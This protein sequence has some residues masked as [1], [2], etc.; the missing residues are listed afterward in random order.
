MTNISVYVP[1]R[2]TEDNRFEKE[3]SLRDRT[4]TPICHCI[5]NS[6]TSIDS[7]RIGKRR[8]VSEVTSG[9]KYVVREESDSLIE[10]D[11]PTA[12][13][14]YEYR[15]VKIT[16]RANRTN[17]LHLTYYQLI[18]S[19]IRTRFRIRAWRFRLNA[20]GMS[21]RGM[22]GSPTPERTRIVYTHHIYSF[23][24]Y[25]FNAGEKN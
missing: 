15:Y 24:G 12:W 25:C 6:F 17:P 19:L 2:W 18:C 7:R 10:Y 11:I 22:R 23:R 20:R 13:F 16:R 1:Q 9:R 21:V 3:W 5:L 8:F 14:T 4:S